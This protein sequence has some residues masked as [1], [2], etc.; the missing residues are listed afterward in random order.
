MLQD[1]INKSKIEC[2]RN[3]IEEL[4]A[5]LEKNNLIQTIPAKEHQI[6]D[7]DSLDADARSAKNELMDP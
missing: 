3:V 5:M 1:P 7:E 2:A 4:I 6:L